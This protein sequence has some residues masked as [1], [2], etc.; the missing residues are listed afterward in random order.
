[1]VMSLVMTYALY[2]KLYV[3][4]NKPF[5]TKAP[6]STHHVNLN[7]TKMMSMTNPSL[8]Q[9]V[10]NAFKLFLDISYPSVFKMALY[11]SKYAYTL[12][13]NNPLPHVILTSEL[14][15]DPSVLDH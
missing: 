10:S 11:V 2:S 12:I 6:P 7:G 1:M 8:F 14:E 9:G 5:L 15:W 3:Q 13:M 4:L